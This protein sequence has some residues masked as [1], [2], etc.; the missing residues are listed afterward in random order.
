MKKANKIL[1]VILVVMMV[2]SIIPITSS[3][4]TYSGTCGDNLTWTYD[5]ITCTLTISGTGCMNNFTSEYGHVDTPW[6]KHRVYIKSIIIEDGVTTIG[7]HAFNCCQS[8]ESVT[9]PTTITDI[10]DYAFNDCDKLKEVIIPNS[11]QKI[12]HRAFYSCGLLTNITIPESVTS[13]GTSAFAYCP[14]IARITVDSNNQYYSNDECGVL[15]NKDKTTLVMFTLGNENTN[16]SIPDGVKIIAEEAFMGCNSLIT[17]TLPNSVTT[18]GNRAFNGCTSI[19]NITLPDS[20]TTIG[21]FAF[22]YCFNLTSV[23][24]PNGLSKISAYLFSECKNLTSISFPDSVTTIGRS[25][26]YN[27]E[28]LIRVTFGMG[29]TLIDYYAFLDSDSI[30]DVFYPGTEEQWKKNVRIYNDTA[31]TDAVMHYE[32]DNDAIV[33]ESFVDHF[34][35]NYNFTT[36]VLT[37][38]GKGDMGDFKSNN[39]PWERFKTV[40]KKVV[41]SDDLTNVGENAFADFTKV[42][43]VTISNDVTGIGDRAFDGCYG[44]TEITIPDS[45]TSIG[46]YAF[47]YCKNLESL[48]IGSGVKTIGAWAF[49]DCVSLT[50]ITIPEN[51]DI[52]GMCAFA[53]CTNLEAF[54]VDSKNKCYSND[55]YGVLFNKDKTTLIQYPSGSTQ[56]NYVISNGVNTLC[57]LAFY[58]SPSC[59]ESVVIPE[60]VTTLET[61][62]FRTYKFDLILYYKG[63]QAQW[64]ELLANNSETSEYLKNYTVNCIDNTTYPSGACGDNLIW[65]FNAHTSTLTISGTGAMCDY[66]IDDISGFI[67]Q[68]WYD[69]SRNIKHIVVEDGVTSIGEAAFTSCDVTDITI[70]DS[71]ASIGSEALDHCNEL[72]NIIVDEDNPYYSN[73]EFGVLF[74][75]DKTTLIYY[76][77]GS[78]RESY[79]I[80]DG[81]ATIKQYAFVDCGI[82]LKSVTV[83]KSVTT[84]EQLAI[85]QYSA[86]TSF[87]INYLG[88]ETEWNAIDG[89]DDGAFF[90]IGINYNYIPPFTGIKDNHFYKDDVMQKAYQLVEFNGDF[91]FI[92]DRHQIVKNKT[93]YLNEARI[94]GLTYADGTPIA[95][96]YY[97]FDENGKMIMREGII[98]NS[99]Y[100]NN[101]LL[102]A[103][104]LVEVDGDFYFI[105][106]RHEIVKNKRI[107]LNEARI[108]GLT[109]ADGTPITP[110][111][112]NV[113]ENGKLIIL[114]GIVGNNVY[115][116]NTKLKAYQLVEVDGDFYLIGDRH[117]IVKNKRIYLNEARINGLTYADGTPIAVGYYNVDADGKMIIE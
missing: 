85:S 102:K 7:N 35:W 106:D 51:V 80:P 72:T 9:I 36:E 28:N 89:S 88:T 109:Y 77:L 84:I 96:G 44:L 61:S 53:N 23:N 50:E 10:G 17:L 57:R 32:Y 24:I 71:V 103:Y 21:E 83:P 105:G 86:F 63:T 2:L 98:G 104:Q 38:S 65:T 90:W 4:A 8:L 5:D 60:S 19:T 25:A 30:T 76:P 100:K 66:E 73:D 20:I 33:S 52:I 99:I 47:D 37:V 56:T 3:A 64:N 12:G 113:D 27:C 59:L 49:A 34:T 46:E 40:A 74:N 22:A 93:V 97:N 42:I 1:S 75:K 115:K 108:N 107:Y 82:V 43:D 110:G 95:P 68:P 92:G 13:I 29:L 15:F 48:S 14:Q 114:N 79:T 26:F 91:Y 55:E 6:Y 117:E 16:Y 67:N 58:Y 11:L 18:I 94:N 39:R 87:V 62:A 78:Q 31:L 54:K 45:V 41:I 81:V 69:F 111:Y 116:N 112:Y 70:G 101:T